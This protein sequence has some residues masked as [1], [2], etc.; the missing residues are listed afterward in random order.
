MATAFRRCL[1]NHPNNDQKTHLCLEACA[2]G[3]TR[4]MGSRSSKAQTGPQRIS[5]LLPEPEPEPLPPFPHLN[6]DSFQRTLLKTLP[7]ELLD[8]ITFYVRPNLPPLYATNY[9]TQ[10]KFGA[11]YH[12]PVPEGTPHN[13]EPP[14]AIAIDLLTDELYVA[15][16]P[17]PHLNLKAEIQVFSTQGQM[18]RSFNQNK[19]LTFPT[20]MVFDGELLVADKGPNPILVFDPSGR[21]KKTIGTRWDTTIEDGDPQPDDVLDPSALAISPDGT[22]LLAE[23]GRHKIHFFTRDG[24][25]LKSI[26]SYGTELGE[27]STPTGV[28]LILKATSMSL[29]MTARG[30]N[31]SINMALSRDP[32]RFRPC[33]VQDPS[34]WLQEDN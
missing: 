20:A 4:E 34:D 21:L 29:K 33:L 9:T 13:T 15:R 8:R 12:H 25:W 23:T 1:T 17:R 27:F 14:E 22:I 26:G 2:F 24:V 7:S 28:L 10:T 5:N 16:P 31:N 3:S 18:L 19:V 30:S 32:W 11:G 6:S